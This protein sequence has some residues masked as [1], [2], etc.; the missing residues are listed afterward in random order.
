MCIF[1]LSRGTTMNMNLVR[2]VRG[3]NIGPN[4]NIPTIVGVMNAGLLTRISEV[5]VYKHGSRSKSSGYQ[6][7]PSQSRVSALARGIL[8]QHVD[9]PTAVLLSSM[10]T[11]NSFQQFLAND[12]EFKIDISESENIKFYVVDGQHRIESLKKAI[13]DDPA[14]GVE[15]KKIKI[16]FVCMLNANEAQEMAQFHIINTNAKPVSTSLAFTLLKERSE[17]DAEFSRILEEKGQKWKIDAQIIAEKIGAQDG[18]WQKRIR[19]ANM[20]K[21]ITTTSSANFA[22]SLRPVLDSYT[23]K[24]EPD[25]DKKIQIVTAY[26]NAVSR[27]VP[28]AFEQ[29][30]KYN[31]QKGLGVDIIHGVYP[32]IADSV[33]GS[34]NSLYN[35]DSYKEY[36]EN[37]L[38]DLSGTNG[39]N[40]QVTG[41][42]FWRTGRAGAA[43]S[44][45]AAAGKRRL[46]EIII[47][48]LEKDA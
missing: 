4:R 9:L 3:S 21:G 7:L 38:L 8:E 24:K 20:E 45:S 31:I 35:P 29:P 41:S 26:W 46:T 6:R 33:R 32:A 44:F 14:H 13:H 42:D 43:G 23:L 2:A 19:L 5:P 11:P 36:L 17:N 22:K 37:G 39:S 18:I 12:E 1:Y 47:A 34:G 48:Q 10:D 28:E 15:I 16:P 27:A 30:L 40:Q 25:I